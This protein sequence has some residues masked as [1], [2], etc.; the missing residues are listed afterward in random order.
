MDDDEC[1]AIGGIAGRG[2][3]STRRKP[4]PV[5]LCS[6]QIPLDLTR[7]RT[8]AATAGS[9]LLTVGYAEINL[10]LLLLFISAV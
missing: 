7:A 2:N 9:Q 8:R 3:R 5:S 6:S 10:S 4:A 1:G